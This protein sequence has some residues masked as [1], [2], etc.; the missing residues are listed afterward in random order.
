MDA[1]QIRQLVEPDL[2]KIKGVSG[3][4]SPSKGYINVYIQST[5][6]VEDELPATINGL[7]VVAIKIGKLYASSLLNEYISHDPLDTLYPDVDQSPFTPRAATEPG[8]TQ[9]VR[10]VPGGVSIGNPA[11]TA[12]TQ[13]CS[14]RP[15]G[16]V[17]GLSNNHVLAAQSTIQNPKAKIGDA[18]IQPGTYD[19]GTLNDRV[20]TLSYFKPLDKLNPNNVDMGV[21][22]P[23]SESELADEILGESAINGT[24]KLMVGDPVQKSGRTT[25]YTQG[26]V[27]DN[28]ATVMV[29]YTDFEAT[30]QH[31][32]I[33]SY[34]SDPGDSGSALLTMDDRLGGLLFAGSQDVTVHNNVEYILA[35]LGLQP[36]PTP[37]TGGGGVSPLAIIG[38]LGAVGLTYILL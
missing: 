37:I 4:G 21:W 22:M 5:N 10:P 16:I 34:M 25:G 7:P 19:G 3:V 35:A 11:I 9:R 17:G 6:P 26:T 13:G 30:F 8:R 29:Q 33:T 36:P 14:L 12:G 20:G 32:V 31:Q 18:I 28:D 27:I 23:D 38:L 1:Q 15:L 2:L 24:R